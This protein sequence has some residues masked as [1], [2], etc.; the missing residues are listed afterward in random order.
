[1]PLSQLPAK[2][3]TDLRLQATNDRLLRLAELRHYA[4]DTPVREIAYTA[5]G[6]VH[7]NP[8]T[9]LAN[10]KS[11]ERFWTEVDKRL[12]TNS[13]SLKSGSEDLIENAKTMFLND[14]K[15]FGQGEISKEHNSTE[16]A[17]YDSL[18]S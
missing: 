10:A 2:A 11:N 4:D 3:W 15:K 17:Q 5:D 1:M 6:Q 8:S 18:F 7:R 14:F 9:N 13:K 16:S 12:E